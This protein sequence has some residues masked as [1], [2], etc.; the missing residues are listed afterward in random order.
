MPR[1]WFY[2]KTPVDKLVKY[3]TEQKSYIIQ[4]YTCCPRDT[5]SPTESILCSQTANNNTLA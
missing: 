1:G 3:N 4:Q 2:D 5:K